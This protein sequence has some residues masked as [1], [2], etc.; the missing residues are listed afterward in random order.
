MSDDS[1][2]GTARGVWVPS[3]PSSDS[4]DSEPY[5]KRTKSGRE[6]KRKRVPHKTR[7]PRGSRRAHAKRPKHRSRGRSSYSSAHSKGPPSAAS[8]LLESGTEA[9]ESG[10][11][12]S[13]DVSVADAGNDGCDV[14]ALD[15]LVYVPELDRKVFE[16]WDVL[17]AYLRTYS[18]RTFQI[19]LVRTNTPAHKRNQRI[20]ENMSA[21]TLIPEEVQFYNKTYVCTHHGDPRQNRGQGRRPHQNSRKIGC[22]A[23][24]NACVQDT[25]NWEVRI[26][27]QVTGHNHVVSSEAYQTYH[28]ARVVSDDEVIATV[29]TLHRAGAN[30]KRI[31]EY[32]VESTTVVP[33]LKDVHNLVAR[34]QQGTYGFPHIEDRIRAILED[35]ASQE[36]N[37]AR[38]YEN[39][40]K[41]LS[42]I[43]RKLQMGS[44][45][46]E[47]SGASLQASLSRSFVIVCGFRR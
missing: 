5:T 37:I 40:C 23:Q 4:S 38:V 3:S 21:Y 11:T 15:E 19:N 32:I 12:S 13:M 47:S 34:L 30:R 28:E 8:E 41:E 42:Y 36:E 9:P 6:G 7:S 14:V 26:T 27:K 31:L 35:F 43:C 17:E 46:E 22:K 45:C 39:F 2:G 18:R 1:D 44:H 24:I 10:P 33:Q 25:G 29:Q 16:S 20:N